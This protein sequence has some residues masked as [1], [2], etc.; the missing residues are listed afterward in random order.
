M[1][2]DQILNDKQFLSEFKVARLNRKGAQSNAGEG[3][4]MVKTVDKK[5]DMLDE[6]TSN[7]V[8]LKPKA[9][10]TNTSSATGIPVGSV[11]GAGARAGAGAGSGASKQ[12]L[13]SKKVI[14]E[15]LQ[16]KTAEFQTPT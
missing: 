4:Q 13:K 12:P 1:D 14:A 10:K 8:Q 6:M 3:N 16:G 2:K 5:I 11:A 15:M 9:N 7:P